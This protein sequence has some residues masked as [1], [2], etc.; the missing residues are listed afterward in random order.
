M[1]T[2][3]LCLYAVACCCCLY[4]IFFSAVSIHYSV[5]FCPVMIYECI[6]TVFILLPDS[7]L[8]C[9]NSIADAL[10]VFFPGVCLSEPVTDVYFL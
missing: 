3:V 1:L 9:C 10:A 7:Q 4:I 6:I 2:I 5:L 8:L